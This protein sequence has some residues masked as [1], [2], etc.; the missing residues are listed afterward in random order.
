MAS[1][2]IVLYHWRVR[3]P[4]LRSPLWEVANSFDKNNYPIVEHVLLFRI[5]NIFAI[6]CQFATSLNIKCKCEKFTN[7]RRTTGDKR[8]TLAFSSDNVIITLFTV[9]IYKYFKRV[10]TYRIGGVI[11]WLWNKNVFRIHMCLKIIHY[12]K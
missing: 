1:C 2:L 5:I 7:D 4:C 10:N 6:K 12:I 11:I 8:H 3:S 9:K